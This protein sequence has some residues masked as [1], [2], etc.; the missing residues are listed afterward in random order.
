[1]NLDRNSIR[2]KILIPV[3]ALI[4]VVSVVLLLILHKTADKISED[5]L[6][7]VME[8]HSSTV[9]KILSIAISELVMAQLLDQTVV[10]EAKKKAVIDEI[11]SYWAGDNLD[12]LIASGEQVIFSSLSPARSEEV[13]RQIRRDEKHFHEDRGFRHSHGIV[14]DLPLWN[15]R[16]IS[17]SK[18]VF[19]VFSHKEM[20]LL[21]SIIPIGLLL[22]LSSV[23]F[24]LNRNFHRPIRRIISDIERG[25]EVRETGITELDRVS[26]AF[27]DSFGNLSRMTEYRRFDP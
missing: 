2:F 22:M 19:P 17:L 8:A 13:L 10:V 7:S 1:M 11:S 23:L 25:L 24:V 9:Q 6:R 16:V 15:W 14:I 12:G 4:T 3:V 20:A 5:Q 21:L 27:N 26:A 18:P